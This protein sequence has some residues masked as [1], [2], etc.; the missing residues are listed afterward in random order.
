MESTPVEEIKEEESKD[1]EKSEEVAPVV[2]EPTLT[3]ETKSEEV[4]EEAAPVVEEESKS[5]EKTEE[6]TEEAAPVEEKATEARP[7]VSET[8]VCIL[9]Y[10]PNRDT[11]S[12]QTEE[13]KEV[14]ESIPVEESI[15]AHVEEPTSTTEETI[16]AAE[17]TSAPVEQTQE[18]TFA[19]ADEFPTPAPV[20]DIETPAAIEIEPPF[21]QPEEA[22]E[23]VKEEEAKET[24]VSHAYVSFG[25][26]VSRIE[27]Y[28]VSDVEADCPSR[29]RSRN[30]L[31]LRLARLCLWLVR[32]VSSM[33][34]LRRNMLT[35]KQIEELAPV[36]QAPVEVISTPQIEGT[37]AVA[38]ETSAP[39]VRNQNFLPLSHHQLTIVG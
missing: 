23:E 17:E 21:V 36:E 26:L 29:S 30:L 28:L 24:S 37:P 18:E 11:N 10:S 7:E 33:F 4:K 19:P 5:E 13:P 14:S 22:K 27:S 6:K 15:A 3:E 8:A 1:E 12:T 32:N 2:A 34:W 9:T 35:V 20:T 16:A 38:E 31:K 39:A 25:L